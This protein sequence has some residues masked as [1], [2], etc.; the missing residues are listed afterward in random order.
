MLPEHISVQLISLISSIHSLEH[1]AFEAHIAGIL[2]FLT[3]Q[4]AHLIQG[5]IQVTHVEKC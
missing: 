1:L 3:K 2:W 5:I 4:F